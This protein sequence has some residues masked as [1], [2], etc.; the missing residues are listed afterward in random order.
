MKLIHVSKVTSK[1]QV[2]VPKDVREILDIKPGD[3]I[4]WYLDEKNRVFIQKI[5]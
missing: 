3:K 1:Y 2:T 4:A 5:T